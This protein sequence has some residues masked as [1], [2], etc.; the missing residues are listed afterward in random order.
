MIILG[1]KYDISEK[2]KALIQKNEI[3]VLRCIQNGYIHERI[4][5]PINSN[6]VGSLTIVIYSHIKKTYTYKGSLNDVSVEEII[7][8]KMVEEFTKQMPSTTNKN[9]EISRLV[10]ILEKSGYLTI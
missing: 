6:Q 4:I 7:P 5:R 2:A 9:N 1:K 8:V 3:L 10:Y